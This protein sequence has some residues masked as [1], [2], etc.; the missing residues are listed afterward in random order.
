MARNVFGCRRLGS[1]FYVNGDEPSG[2]IKEVGYFLTSREVV[3]FS[4]NFLHHGVSK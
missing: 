4:N 1:S 3:S 2:S